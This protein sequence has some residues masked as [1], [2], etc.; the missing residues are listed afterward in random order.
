MNPVWSVAAGCD[1]VVR[2][3]DLVLW[4]CLVFYSFIANF[5]FVLLL[6][7]DFGGCVVSFHS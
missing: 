2:V 4:A 1:K 6:L 7:V 3:T 5:V